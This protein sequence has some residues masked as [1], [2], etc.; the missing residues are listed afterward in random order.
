MSSF[1]L[2]LISSFSKRSGVIAAAVTLGAEPPAPRE[3]SSAERPVACM[4]VGQVQL[5]LAES[6]LQLG[7][8]TR[9]RHR[10]FDLLPPQ[11]ANLIAQLRQCFDLLLE[12]DADLQLKAEEQL[13]CR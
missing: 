6:A 9:D 2:P 1:R 5:V 7:Q 4:R 11:P 3:F 10:D 12:R 8:A 13:R